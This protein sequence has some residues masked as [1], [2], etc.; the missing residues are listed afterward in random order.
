MNKLINEGGMIVYRLYTIIRA[1][2]LYNPLLCK[3]GAFFEESGKK[4]IF[5]VKYIQIFLF[6]CFFMK[7]TA[8]FREKYVVPTIDN[9]YI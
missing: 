6:G 7:K 5:K 3:A 9:I 1:P 4:Y 8:I 2:A